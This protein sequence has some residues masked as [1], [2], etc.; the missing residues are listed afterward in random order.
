MNH[1]P[2]VPTSVLISPGIVVW[3]F[4]FT[5]QP[6]S[7]SFTGPSSV[8]KILAPRDYINIDNKIE[9]PFGKLKLNFSLEN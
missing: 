9:I 6:K 3:F 4:N 7:P 2:V 8:R 1:K 5:A